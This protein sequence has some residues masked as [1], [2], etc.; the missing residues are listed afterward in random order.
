MLLFACK[1]STDYQ[2]AGSDYI[3]IEAKSLRDAQHDAQIEADNYRD[4][5]ENLLFSG[6]D[7]ED[8]EYIYDGA[9]FELVEVSNTAIHPSW[10]FGN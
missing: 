3:F 7:E 5:V 8:R 2:E 1:L 10:Y 6:E 9:Y 4:H